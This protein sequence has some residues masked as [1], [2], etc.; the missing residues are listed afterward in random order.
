MVRV[1]S[2]ETFDEVVKE[3]IEEFDMTPEEAVKDAVRQ[4]EAQV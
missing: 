1:I 3:N 2:Q 4:F